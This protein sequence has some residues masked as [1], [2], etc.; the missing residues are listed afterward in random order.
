MRL[1][2]KLK[3][4]GGRPVNYNLINPFINMLN[5]CKLVHLGS[6]G[7][8]FTWSNCRRFRNDFIMERLDKCYANLEWMN[9]FPSA[10]VLTLP[11]THSDHHPI[12]LSLSH[13]FHKLKNSILS[14]SPCGSDILFLLPFWLHLG[15]RA[16]Q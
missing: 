16:G 5:S 13:E 8:K 12:R 7:P 2:T 6:S 3:S 15:S 9:L 14:L 4:G 1:L 10:S 11:K